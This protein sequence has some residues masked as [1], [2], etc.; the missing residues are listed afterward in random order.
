[1]ND[2]KSVDDE[3][4][5]YGFFKTKNWTHSQNPEK[6]LQVYARFQ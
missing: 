4:T 5:A 2:R 6:N 3:C 1:M